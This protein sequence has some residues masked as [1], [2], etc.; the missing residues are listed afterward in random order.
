MSKSK[1]SLDWLTY[2]AIIFDVESV[3]LHGEGFAFSM[4]VTSSLQEV[5]HLTVACQ[6]DEV[7]GYSD[8][9]AWVKQH[10]TYPPDTIWLKTTREVRSVFWGEWLRLNNLKYKLCADVSWPVESN[11][12]SACVRDNR[13]V[14]QFAGPYPL[15][16]LSTLF[17]LGDLSKHQTRLPEHMPEHNPLAD[18]RHS[19][20]QT[21]EIVR[22]LSGG[23]K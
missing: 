7:M 4:V 13:S 23:K 1:P 12:L 18:C 16:D 5:Q 14:R 3:G 21:K 9:L 2:G 6:P 20:R 10:V 8:D 17:M 11:F 19:L 22:Q 15:I